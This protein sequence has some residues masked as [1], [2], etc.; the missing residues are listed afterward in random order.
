MG[1]KIK[2]AQRMTDLANNYLK[3]FI[4]VADPRDYE[5]DVDM[6]I[7]LC[8]TGPCMISSTIIDKLS[9]TFHLDRTDVLNKFIKQLELGLRYVDHRNNKE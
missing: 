5:D 3:D 1:L 2:D 6:F 4:E 9:G 8:I 7:Q